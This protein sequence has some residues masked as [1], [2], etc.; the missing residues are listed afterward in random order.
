LDATQSQVSELVR[1]RNSQTSLSF[2]VVPGNVK[3][4]RLDVFLSMSEIGLS[5]S[6]IQ[7]LIR[8]R[9]IQVNGNLSKPSR[10]LKGGDKVSIHVPPPSVINLTPQ[11]VEFSVVYED[12]SLI[13]V[14]K[15]AGVVVHPAPGHYEGTLVH[16]LLKHCKDLSGIGGEL[17]P[18]IV[19]R[20]DKDTSGLMVV[21]KNDN[22][23][24]SL[25][26]Q[27]KN[28]A[29]RKKYAAIV[30]GRLKTTEGEV[31]LPIGRHP[32]KR[33]KMAVLPKG[34]RQAITIWRKTEEFEAG[35]SFLSILLK[36]GRTHQIRVHM[37]HMGH[38]LA[39][40]LVYGYGPNWWKRNFST[41]KRVSCRAE[42]QMLHSTLLGFKHPETDI[43]MEFE[44]PL[45][46]D[47]VEM[48]EALR[49][50]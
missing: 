13:V 36:T 11:D 14:S 41:G 18:G 3:D 2:F 20:L 32:V 29:I 28:G 16:G 17:R 43:F 24:L 38:P 35:F 30:H 8:D 34:G 12:R 31:N 37:S 47:M 22:A 26:G 21:A 44:S 48:L 6:R 49:K 7:S 15:P 46:Q 45:P 19:H 42:R 5:R 25:A 9:N 23:H 4:I 50:G 27:F 40:D 39:G 10:R 33:K 1:L